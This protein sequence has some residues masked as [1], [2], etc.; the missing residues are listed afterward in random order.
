MQRRLKEKRRTFV[1]QPPACR[2]CTGFPSVPDAAPLQGSGPLSR[3]SIM[4][5]RTAPVKG[6]APPRKQRRA[7]DRHGPGARGLCWVSGK[8]GWPG[9]HPCAVHSGDK[10]GVAS[11]DSKP[12]APVCAPAVPIQPGIAPGLIETTRTIRL[13]RLRRGPSTRPTSPS[14]P[15]DQPPHQHR[16]RHPPPRDA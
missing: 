5:R 11:S 1:L 4:P 3:S 16:D 12:V 6:K 10:S 8:G 15:P 2:H 13:R 14:P 7:L 9:A